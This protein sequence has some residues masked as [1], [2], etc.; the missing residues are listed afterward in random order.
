VKNEGNAKFCGA[1]GKPVGEGASQSETASGTASQPSV[2][3]PNK[4]STC[5]ATVESFQTRCTS[6][7]SE[8]NI[9]GSMESV[10]SFFKKLDDISQ[11]EYAA[12]KALEGKNGK[13]KVKQPKI[14]VLCEVVAI[15]S[16]ILLILYFTPPAKM[17]R[18]G[19]PIDWRYDVGASHIEF[20]I[21]NDSEYDTDDVIVVIIAN[22]EQEPI[23]GSETL[24]ERWGEVRLAD[25]AG[26]YLVYAMDRN[27]NEF[28]YPETR[29]PTRMSGRIMLSYDG[30][31][32]RRY[33]ERN[34]RIIWQP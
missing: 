12:N 28:F 18:G 16:I 9:A 13:K 31:G 34:E 21:S 15:I 25:R 23:G 1:C 6:C 10:Q 14:V 20:I 32:F 11:K 3:K 17:L 24:L 7:G 33:V 8:I 27:Q 30:L 4:C 26:Y 22:R 2:V 29:E 19:D 5:G